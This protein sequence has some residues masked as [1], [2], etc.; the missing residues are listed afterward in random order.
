MQVQAHY[1]G[2]RGRRTDEIACENEGDLQE[3]NRNSL[4]G[5]ENSII[6]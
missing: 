3:I 1:L 2:M 4:S 5:K 6:I